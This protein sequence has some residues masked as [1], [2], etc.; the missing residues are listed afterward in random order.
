LVKNETVFA[1]VILVTLSAV[2]VHFLSRHP[3]IVATLARASPI[4]IGGGFLFAAAVAV[5]PS[6]LF[7]RVLGACAFVAAVLAFVLMQSSLYSGM[8]NLEPIWQEALVGIAG[9]TTGG[10]F[11]V[12]VMLLFAAW[13]ASGSSVATDWGKRTDRLLVTFTALLLAY[14]FV[15][16]VFTGYIFTGYFARYLS[17]TIF[18][19]DLFLALGLVAMIDCVRGWYVS[20]KRSVSWR[21]LAHV[22]G[23]AAAAVG[24][25][26]VVLYWG[27]LQT[28]LFRKLP[29]DQISFF[30]LVSTPPFRGATF[31]GSIYGGTLAYFSRSWAYFDANSALAQGSVT[32]GPDG[33]RVTR[34]DAYLW[35]AD[36]AVNAAYQK[37]KYFLAMTFL[38]HGFLQ[39]RGLGYLTDDQALRLRVGDVPLIRDVR[40]GRTSYLNPIEVARDPS[41]LDRWSIVRLDWDFPPFLRLLEN[42]EFVGL[43]ISPTG[44]G[45]RIRVDYR[46]AQQEGV[47]ETGTRVTLLAQSRCAGAEQNISLSPLVAGGHEFILPVSFVGTVRAEVQPATATKAGPIYGS[48]PLEIGFQDICRQSSSVLK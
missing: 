29:P 37:P 31:A 18:L 45:T 4:V 47:P 34:D 32:L 30:P 12:S 1:L 5:A 3:E 20:I 23:A 26:G 42:G 10:A 15:F 8:G 2:I 39:G 48:G 36:R 13:H 28:F 40:E 9:Y 11:F 38:Y 22:S 33:Y 43:D 19:N 46:Y 16:F 25:T 41:P 44:D 24:L 35:F 6:E 7:G 27:S 14:L 21:R 17:L